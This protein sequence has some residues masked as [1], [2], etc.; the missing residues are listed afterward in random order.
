MRLGWVDGSNKLVRNWTAGRDAN[1]VATIASSP[2]IQPLEHFSTRETTRTAAHQHPCII[3]QSSPPGSSYLP[4][5]SSGFCPFANVVMCHYL[6]VVSNVVS[7][8]IYNMFSLFCLVTSMHN[9]PVSQRSAT[10]DKQQ[11]DR[12]LPLP[13]LHSGTTIDPM[14]VPREITLPCFSDTRRQANHLF[15]VSRP[16]HAPERERRKCS[17]IE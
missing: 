8:L 1:S 6:A 10:G 7:L 16:L 5:P 15:T 11:D 2:P 13:T 14:Q 9:A 3:Y 17:Y 4:W 12:R